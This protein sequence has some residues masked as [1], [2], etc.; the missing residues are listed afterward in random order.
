MIFY[1]DQA[2]LLPEA[3]KYLFFSSQVK[4]ML[5]IS[6]P[7]LPPA[8]RLE[9]MQPSLYAPHVD[10]TRARLGFG[11]VGLRIINRELHDPD[12]LVQLQ[13]LHTIMDQVHKLF[14]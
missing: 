11:R 4:K 3:L 13:A 8:Q 12:Q 14:R 5:T 2:C 10:I 6:L 9:S 1:V 7:E